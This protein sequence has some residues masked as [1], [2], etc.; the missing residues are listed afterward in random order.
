MD[1][2][3]NKDPPKPVEQIRELVKQIDKDLFDIKQDILFI[4]LKIKEREEKEKIQKLSGG[5]WLF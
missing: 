5:W 4:K 1:I 2:E 3:T